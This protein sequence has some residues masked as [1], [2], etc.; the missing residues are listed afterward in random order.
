M[1][2]I[3]PN[4]AH[5][6]MAVPLISEGYSSVVWMKIT[7]PLAEA[8]NF[9]ALIKQCIIKQVHEMSNFIYLTYKS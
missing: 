1:P 7:E 9:P 3:L 2:P 4:S 6:P 8:P 5:R